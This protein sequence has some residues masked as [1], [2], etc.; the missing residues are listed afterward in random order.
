[1]TSLTARLY[2]HCILQVDTFCSNSSQQSPTESVFFSHSFNGTVVKKILMESKTFGEK[3][4]CCCV[5]ST[6]QIN[7]KLYQSISLVF[8]K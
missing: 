5:Y 8:F 3:R 2:A 6:V 7:H 4:F 1:M